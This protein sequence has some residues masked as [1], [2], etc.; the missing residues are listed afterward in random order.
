[1]PRLPKP[2]GFDIKDKATD[3]YDATGQFSHLA[4]AAPAESA[5]TTTAPYEAE[6]GADTGNQQSGPADL[7]AGNGNRAW[8]WWVAAALALAVL[9]AV[10]L[11]MRGSQR[12]PSAPAANPAPA[13]VLP[14]RAPAVSSPASA[15]PRPSARRPRRRPAPPRRRA[16]PVRRRSARPIAV[17]APRPVRSPAAPVQRPA[18]KPEP[19]GGEFI[20]GAR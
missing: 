5:D 6:H 12:R 14:A 18:P 10:V 9:L 17:A 19:A 8:R 2:R 11:T 1:M 4:A 15:A 13:A 20:L 3:C 16:R 7:A